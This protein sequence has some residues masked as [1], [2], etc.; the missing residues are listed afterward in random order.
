MKRIIFDTD[1]GCDCDDAGALAILHECERAGKAELL[2]VT[3]STGSPYAAGCADAINRRYGHILPI[4]QTDK[5]PPGEDVGFYPQSYG[6]HIAETF[7]NEYLPGKGKK[8][9]NAVRLLRRLL[10]QA[11]GKVTIVAVGSMVN[12]AG[13]LSGGADDLSPLSGRELVKERVEEIALMGCFF[14]S[15][16]VP[17]VWFGT[18]KMEAE[19]NIAADIASARE[20][21]DKSPVPIAVAHYLVGLK[22]R[23][24]GILLRKDRKNPVAEAYFVHSGG[25]RESWDLV[26]AYYAVFGEDGIFGLSP[27]GR[28][29][30]DERGVSVFIPCENGMH[31]LIGCRDSAA[32]KKRLDGILAGEIFGA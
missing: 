16:E 17:E 7:P 5:I 32:A 29:R 20:V 8:P 25:D 10:A 26:A 4:G 30:I 31:R 24:G 1:I 9:E 23:T 11:G 13:L 21:F 18:T 3:L 6:R 28:V 19:C 14:P 2:G 22:I 27:A 12:L 15:E